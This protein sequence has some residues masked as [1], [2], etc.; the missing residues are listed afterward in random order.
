VNRARLACGLACAAGFFTLPLYPLVITVGYLAGG[1]RPP[2]GAAELGYD[3]LSSSVMWASAIGVGLAAAG[4]A[5]G[6]LYR[7]DVEVRGVA[8]DDDAGLARAGELIGA[9]V[10]VLGLFLLIGTILHHQNSA[11]AAAASGGGG[12]ANGGDQPR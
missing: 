12:A 4:F 10:V 6:W 2:G 1:E 7:R 9:G 3:W 11:A 5:L 8:A